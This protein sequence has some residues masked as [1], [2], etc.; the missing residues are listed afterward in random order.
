M[1]LFYFANVRS[2]FRSCDS[3]TIA[4]LKRSG[5]IGV[6]VGVET[7]NLHDMRLFAKRCSLDDNLAIVQFCR[8][9]GIFISI[10][11][12]KYAPISDEE[13]EDIYWRN[14]NQLWQLGRESE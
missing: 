3:D 7:A 5:L 4:L 11:F 1:D 8:D 14:A 2:S 10:G 13:K 12:I 6:F 9:H